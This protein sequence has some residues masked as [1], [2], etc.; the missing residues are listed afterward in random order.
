M[1]PSH[2]T[3]TGIPPLQ[4]SV[5]AAPAATALTG[6]MLG[7]IF[8]QKI[9]WG[10]GIRTP[11]ARVRAASNNHYTTPHAYPV[12]LPPSLEHYY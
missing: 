4:G 2:G 7:M 8:S 3:W 12:L 1:P 9:G 10:A 11:I 5:Y 6:V